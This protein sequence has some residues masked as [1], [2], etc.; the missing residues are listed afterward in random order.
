MV[1]CL[2]LGAVAVTNSVTARISTSLAC[3]SSQDDT[4][5]MAMD[6]NSIPDELRPFIEEKLAAG[7]SLDE[8]VCDAL[9]LLRF[10]EDF[11]GDHM[12]EIDRQIAEGVA[13]EERGEL[14]DGDVA[15][16]EIRAELDSRRSGG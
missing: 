14:V 15:M 13:A 10:N 7:R 4:Y 1:T 3:R 5:A 8:I 16:A 12:E 11:L 2:C 6:L 9:R